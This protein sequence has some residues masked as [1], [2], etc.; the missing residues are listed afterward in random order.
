MDTT[1]YN[2]YEYADG[3][4]SHSDDGPPSPAASTSSQYSQDDRLEKEDGTQTHAGTSA[5]TATIAQSSIR[6]GSRDLVTHD[7]MRR[8]AFYQRPNVYDIEVAEIEDW[9]MNPRPAP[10]PPPKRLRNL[11]RMISRLI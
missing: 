1:P 11:R 4:P 8:F 6:T 7:T 10:P 3:A 9:G 5:S 2:L